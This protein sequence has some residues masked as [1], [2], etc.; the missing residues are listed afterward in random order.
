MAVA[1][2]IAIPIVAPRAAFGA[3]GSPGAIGG[4][5]VSVSAPRGFMH[6]GH[7]VAHCN[8]KLLLLRLLGLLLLVVLTRLQQTFQKCFL[9]TIEA[10]VIDLASKHLPFQLG[11][12]LP[13][14]GLVV[15]AALGLVQQRLHCPLGSSDWA[16]HR[17]REE[18]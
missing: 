15:V 9:G 3:V 1:V 10:A 16:G 18:L 12:L 2:A 17:E 5:A 13:D 14:G 4:V 7:L 6:S 11:H 8:Q